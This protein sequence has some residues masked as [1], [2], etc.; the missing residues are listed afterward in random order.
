M[1]CAPHYEE[2][3]VIRCKEENGNSARDCRVNTGNHLTNRSVDFQK[4]IGDVKI[5]SGEQ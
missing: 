1:I 2:I 5:S 4:V 3:Q